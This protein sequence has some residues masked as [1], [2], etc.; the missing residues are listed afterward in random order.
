MSYLAYQNSTVRIVAVGE[1]KTNVAQAVTLSKLLLIRNWA[2]Y[3]SDVIV[4]L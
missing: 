2:V 3:T 4:K 1:S